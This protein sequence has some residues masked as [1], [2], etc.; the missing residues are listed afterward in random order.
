LT[1]KKKKEDHYSLNGRT[2][3]E[4]HY[5]FHQWWGERRKGTLRS[6]WPEWEGDISGSTQGQEKKK[7]TTFSISSAG[8]IE[9]KGEGAIV[10]EARRYPKTLRAELDEGKKE[11]PVLPSLQT[12]KEKGE[13]KNGLPPMS[14]NDIEKKKTISSEQREGGRGGEGGWGKPFFSSLAGREGRGGRGK[15]RPLASSSERG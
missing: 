13:T 15:E 12:R 9:K 8:G 4:E 7:Q 11:R 14:A 1:G 3:R 2:E 5:F 10:F 6:S